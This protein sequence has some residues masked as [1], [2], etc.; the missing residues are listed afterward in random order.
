M[1]VWSCL[2][3]PEK[4]EDFHHDYTAINPNNL[5]TLLFDACVSSLP[6]TCQKYSILRYLTKTFR[7]NSPNTQTTADASTQ[8]SFDTMTLP[9]TNYV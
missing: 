7:K 1:I 6:S 8:T 2:D 5:A 4:L 3:R 9:E